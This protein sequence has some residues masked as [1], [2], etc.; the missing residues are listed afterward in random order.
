[1]VPFNRDIYSYYIL[2]A[3]S[4]F[5]FLLLAECKLFCSDVIERWDFIQVINIWERI[6][7]N[8]ICM[9]LSSFCSDFWEN[10]LQ[11]HKR[12]IYESWATK[13]L[14]WPMNGN[15]H[16]WLHQ[17]IND[18]FLL[19]FIHEWI[20]SNQYQGMLSSMPISK[21]ENGNSIEGSLYG[22]FVVDHYVRVKEQDEK[23]VESDSVNRFQ[24]IFA[25]G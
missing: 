13:Y 15:P 18:N 17:L 10:V 16:R 9:F 23:H 21:R 20:E 5:S 7:L 4:C 12:F 8:K 11:R 19:N 6:K 24:F 2:S 22:S 1:M 3:C 25:F 14:W